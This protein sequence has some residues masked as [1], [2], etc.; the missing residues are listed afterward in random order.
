MTRW[1]QERCRPW[2][3]DDDRLMLDGLAVDVTAW[4]DEQERLSTAAEGLESMTDAHQ[5]AE[6]RSR[7]DS[8]TGVFNRRHFHEVLSAE[9]AR[10]ERDRSTPGVLM[11]DIDHF[12]RV[13]DSFGHQAGDEVLVEVA[14]RR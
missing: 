13:N 14:N 3:D 1:V 6:L 10:A 11:V 12:K 4:R 5:E 7:T 9:L 2:R 8:L